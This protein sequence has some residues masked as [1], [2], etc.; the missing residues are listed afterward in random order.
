MTVILPKNLYTTNFKPMR[1]RK[2]FKSTLIIIPTIF[3]VLLSV[4]FFSNL[5]NEKKLIIKNWKSNKMSINQVKLILNKLNSKK[6]IL[7]FGTSR[8]NL[9]SSEILRTKT[10][11]M[12]YIYSYPK[13]VGSF[14]EKLNNKQ[15]NNI[16]KIYFL[17]DYHTLEKKYNRENDINV[18]FESQTNKEWTLNKLKNFN[19]RKIFDSFKFIYNG[20]TGEYDYYINDEGSV[21][22]NKEVK[23]DGASPTKKEHFNEYKFENYFYLKK[24][25]NFAKQNNIEVL[26]FTPIY[27]KEFFDKFEIRLETFLSKILSNINNLYFFMYEKDISNNREY[28]IDESHL[29]YVGIQ[30]WFNLDWNDK[31]INNYNFKEKINKLIN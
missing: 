18:Y 27:P 15:I 23:W 22:S 28:F 14:L 5:V 26:F 29:N 3:L 13:D 4:Y 1:F 17:I 9:V 25:D 6:G 11:N 24:I 12:H 19:H 7:L 30:K 2:F 8:T 16:D 21:V 31:N 10:Y 20:L